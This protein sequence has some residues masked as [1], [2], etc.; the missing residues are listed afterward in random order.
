MFKVDNFEKENCLLSPSLKLASFFD[1]EV[2]SIAP[3]IDCVKRLFSISYEEALKQSKRLQWQFELAQGREIGVKVS[4]GYFLSVTELYALV[5]AKVLETSGTQAPLKSVIVVPANFTDPQRESIIDAA[6]AVEIDPLRLVSETEALIANYE[7]KMTSD[8]DEEKPE[9][10]L[11]VSMGAGTTESALFELNYNERYDMVNC[12]AMTTG[13]DDLDGL[14]MQCCRSEWKLFL[15]DPSIEKEMLSGLKWKCKQAKAEFSNGVKEVEI[16]SSDRDEVLEIT[17]TKQRFE[18]MISGFVLPEF[19]KMLSKTAGDVM[20]K[21]VLLCGG[22][23][24]IPILAN[25]VRSL[26]SKSQFSNILNYS[27]AVAEGA[28][29][30]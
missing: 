18:S 25:S 22:S 8:L 30:F 12:H 7:G 1:D 19:K 17:V 5:L 13:G 29:K 28:G 26:F 24:K 10:V 11:I 9:T 4:P 3:N 15:N 14:L 20:P 21:L 6:N 2:V 16:K 23:M 27:E